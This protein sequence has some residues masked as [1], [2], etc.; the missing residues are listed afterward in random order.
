MLT[1]RRNQFLALVA[2]AC[3]QAGTDTVKVQAPNDPSV[4]ETCLVIC[5]ADQD[6][7]S[8]RFACLPSGASVITEHEKRRGICVRAV[9][10]D[11]QGRV[12]E[13]S[14]RARL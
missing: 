10:V 9:V 7:A 12:S 11:D 5:E 2:I 14:E 13:Q 3:S 8:N 1:K 4:I 6:E